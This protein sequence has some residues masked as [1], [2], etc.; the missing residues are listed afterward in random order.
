MIQISIAS[1]IE[2]IKNN[3]A[4]AYS[5]CERK[6]ATMPQLQNSNNLATTIWS[7]SAGGGTPVKQK[8]V[9]FFDYDGTLL[10]SYTAAEAGELSALPALPLH[11]GL[12]ATGWTHTLS[13][14]QHATQKINVGCL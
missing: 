14:I 6:D 2:R 10:Y 9:N 8:D 1:Q 12:T 4:A 11:S 3:I 13:Q 5:V 7:I